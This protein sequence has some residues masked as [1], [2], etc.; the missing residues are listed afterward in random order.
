MTHSLRERQE[1]FESATDYSLS[2]RVPIIIRI[3]L[4]SHKRLIDNLG[5]PYSV[6]F[7][8]LMSQTMLYVITNIQDALFGYYHTDEITLVLRND[9]EKDTIP[10]HNNNLQKM[11]S[12]VASLA[13]LG[14]YHSKELFADTINLNGDALF[15]VK[16]FTLPSIPEAVNHLI[17]HQSYCMGNAV[18]EAA[19][20]ELSEKFETSKVYSLIKEKSFE[21]KRK[22]LLNHCGIDFFEYYPVSFYHGS[23]VYKEPTVIKT[24]NN[25]VT[26]NKWYINDELP[27]FVENKDFLFNI[28]TNG[29]DVFRGNTIIKNLEEELI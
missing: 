4:K 18:T 5:L 25:S 3:T 7:A 13:T 27:N 26:R 16:I 23:A 20:F 6:D 29:C 21:E 1:I 28:L 14:F 22:L 10:W 12:T 2:W 8:D 9:K 24:K 17:L 15:D 19:A 11:V